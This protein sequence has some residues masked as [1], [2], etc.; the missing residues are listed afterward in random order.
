MHF[1]KLSELTLPMQAVVLAYSQVLDPKN[2]WKIFNC[3]IF[4]FCRSSGGT[5][6]AVTTNRA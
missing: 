4:I 5:A 2:R 1:L 3:G 6:T